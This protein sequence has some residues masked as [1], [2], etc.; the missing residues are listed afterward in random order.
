MAS[1]YQKDSF[2]TGDP[3]HM[4]T[5]INSVLQNTGKTPK[6]SFE[7]YIWPSK[8]HLEMKNFNDSKWQ[9]KF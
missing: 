4:C 2:E 5:Q 3:W 1:Y 9:V 8:M 7:L 6:I